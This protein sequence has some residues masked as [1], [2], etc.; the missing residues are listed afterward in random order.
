MLR[1]VL[2]LLVA[3]IAAVAAI[4]LEFQV[5]AFFDPGLRTPDTW[6]VGFIY[7]VGKLLPYV[8]LYA[9]VVGIAMG[10]LFPTNRW[11]VVAARGLLLAVPPWLVEIYTGF[12]PNADSLLE[13]LGVTAAI[14]AWPFFAATAAVLACMM[15]NTSLARTR[16]G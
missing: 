1:V 4:F 14:F 15:S 2:A 16:E 12:D 13:E 11:T 6:T 7:Y 5:E 3:S 10:R 8:I 9:A